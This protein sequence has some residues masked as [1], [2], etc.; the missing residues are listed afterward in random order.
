VSFRVGSTFTVDDFAETLRS[1]GGSRLALTDV[2]VTQ[3]YCGQ[4]D[5]QVGMRMNGLADEVSRE[6][7]LAT[8]SWIPARL[9]KPTSDEPV[10]VSRGD[11]V[12]TATYWGKK[13]G[14]SVSP[15]PTHWMPMPSPPA[16]STAT[17]ETET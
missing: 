12:G 13:H 17:K 7:G 4:C 8:A 15:A 6:L 3:D 14:W 2:T 9:A 11:E 5:I 10:L 1:F 16:A